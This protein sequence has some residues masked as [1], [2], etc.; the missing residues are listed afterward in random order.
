MQLEHVLQIKGA[1]EKK[2]KVGNNMEVLIG[3][4]SVCCLW[5]K[6]RVCNTS[7]TAEVDEGS[8]T[9]LRKAQVA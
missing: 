4:N 6:C 3:E 2:Y 5:T 9:K 1:M 8:D 7:I